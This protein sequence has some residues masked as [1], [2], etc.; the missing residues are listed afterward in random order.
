MKPTTLHDA[1]ARAITGRGPA[2]QPGAA[3]A[4]QTAAAARGAPRMRVLVAEDH[5]INQRLAMR[6]LEKL[7]AAVDLARDGREAVALAAA[8]R[9]DLVFMDMQMPE[10]DGLEATRRIRAADG[11]EARLP[12]VA[13]T[14]N[15]MAEDR[16]RC[17]GAG[18]NDF[19]TKPID[20][21]AVARML[22]RYMPAAAPGTDLATSTAAGAA[23]A[24]GGVNDRD[25][26]VPSRAGDPG[27]Q[28]AV[29][30]PV[31]VTA[32]AAAIASARMSG[33]RALPAD[34]REALVAGHVAAV[35]ASLA[36][37]RAAVGAGDL[38]ALQAAARRMKA[39]QLE[40]GAAHAAVSV[41]ALESAARR[42]L[43]ADAPARIDA[44]EAA[45]RRAL[46]ELVSLAGD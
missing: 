22:V 13:M 46:A 39:V 20:R 1:L 25:P 10:M 36:A 28:V 41:R 44:I 42:A 40:I 26:V 24:S 14:A 33:L 12:I 21:E 3:V 35:D 30:G 37:M 18:M 31:A 16:D 27:A 2:A 19:L 17:L 34:E 5:E 7:G 6:M 11:P 4:L 15:A 8:N 45:S 38:A 23:V 43:P 32:D 29:A 9:Y